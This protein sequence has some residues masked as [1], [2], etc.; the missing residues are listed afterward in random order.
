MFRRGSL[1]EDGG[2]RGIQAEANWLEQAAASPLAPEW[3]LAGRLA[4]ERSEFSEGCRSSR[5]RAA[6]QT[7]ERQP[8]GQPD[9]QLP[10]RGQPQ[11]QKLRECRVREKQKAAGP[12]RG[13]DAQVPERPRWGVRQGGLLQDLPLGRRGPVNALT[14]GIASRAEDGEHFLEQPDS[15]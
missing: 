7:A 3:G 12:K 13:G 4:R 11:A 14:L 1:A 2:L 15:L 5:R 10:R 9:S 6:L 8:A